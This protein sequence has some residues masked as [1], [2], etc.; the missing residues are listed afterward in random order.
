MNGN[1]IYHVH[2]LEYISLVLLSSKHG[3]RCLLNVLGIEGYW[4]LLS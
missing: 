3:I 4:Y 1:E 2:S